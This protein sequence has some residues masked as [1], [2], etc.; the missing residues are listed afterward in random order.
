M[1][2]ILIEV[3]VINILHL[4]GYAFIAGRSSAMDYYLKI[5]WGPPRAAIPH[6]GQRQH[7]S[8]V[9]SYCNTWK[10]LY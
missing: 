7:V 1:K 10:E 5:H 2:E 6:N 9:Q 8:H 3:A 4:N